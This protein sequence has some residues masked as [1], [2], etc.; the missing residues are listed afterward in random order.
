[1]GCKKHHLL[2]KLFLTQKKAIRIITN[3]AWRAHTYPLF[4]KLSILKI[5]E[6]HKLQVACFMFKVHNSLMPSYFANVFHDINSSGD[7]IAKRD[8]II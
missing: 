4:H 6:L 8:L 1:M 7:E 2:Q 3:S 5:E